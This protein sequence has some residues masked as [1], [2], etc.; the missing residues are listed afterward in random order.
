MKLSNWG[1]SCSLGRCYLLEVQK[2]NRAP[3]NASSRETFG[4][5]LSGLSVV[6]FAINACIIF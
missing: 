4:M 1:D 2:K 3:Y 5:K 6:D